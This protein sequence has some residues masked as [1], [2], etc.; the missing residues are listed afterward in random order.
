MESSLILI[1]LQASAMK[2]KMERVSCSVD[3]VQFLQSCNLMVPMGQEPGPDLAGS[4]AHGL[5]G[6]Q[7]RCLPG[8][9]LM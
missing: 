7:S 1:S 8:C 6:P 3:S 5:E 9:V 2:T 4:S